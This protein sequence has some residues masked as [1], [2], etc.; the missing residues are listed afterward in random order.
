[1]FQKLSEI[2]ADN[3]AYSVARNSGK[4]R[5]IESFVLSEPV[6]CIFHLETTQTSE[7]QAT[8]FILPL[9]IHLHELV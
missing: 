8:V 6:E 9:K 7:S 3:S 5:A 1:M 4:Q 2:F